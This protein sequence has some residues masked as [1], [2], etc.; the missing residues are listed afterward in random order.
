MIL[1]KISF[2]ILQCL[3]ATNLQS[4]AFLMCPQTSSFHGQSA[5]FRGHILL[6]FPTPAQA[7]YNT[8][9]RPSCQ[10]S[11]IPSTDHQV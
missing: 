4:K 6:T 2:T 9:A 11:Q 5:N 3:S 10:S 1:K 7:L 8:Y